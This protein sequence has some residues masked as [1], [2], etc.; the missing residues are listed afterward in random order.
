M[1]GSCASLTGDL[2][3]VCISLVDVLENGTDDTIFWV[4][5]MVSMMIRY[6]YHMVFWHNWA[7]VIEAVFSRHR[8]V[9]TGGMALRPRDRPGIP[10][11]SFK[12]E[13]PYLHECYL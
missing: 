5:Y 8:Q 9:L 6:P 2:R 11:A 12:E 13:A 3:H 1:S 4:R 10:A 7:A